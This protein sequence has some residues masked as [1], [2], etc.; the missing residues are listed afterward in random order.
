MR[1]TLFQSEEDTE[2]PVYSIDG[3]VLMA[4]A[5]S[6][7]A[8]QV[9]TEWFREHRFCIVILIVSSYHHLSSVFSMWTFASSNISFVLQRPDQL[10][11]LSLPTCR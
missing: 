5:D 10:S 3:W 7:M 11:Q 1:F 2:S 4:G 6:K 8:A 9:V